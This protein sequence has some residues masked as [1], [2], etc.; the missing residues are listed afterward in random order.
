MSCLVTAM[1][2]DPE[3]KHAHPEACALP[4]RAGR[5]R[6]RPS[7]YPANLQTTSHRVIEK[8]WRTRAEP[9]ICMTIGNLPDVSLMGAELD[10]R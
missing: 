10:I 3:H 9:P 1:A 7:G 4:F 6:P 2:D 5:D 8:F